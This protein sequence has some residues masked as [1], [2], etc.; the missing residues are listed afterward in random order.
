MTVSRIVYDPDVRFIL[1]GGKGGVGKTSCA[2]AISILSAEQGLRTLIVS[3]DPAH[4]LSD[5]FDQNLSGGEAV[6]IEQVRD[7]WGM[8]VDT[9][10]GMREFQKSIGSGVLGEETSMAIALIGDLDS[11]TPPGADEAMSFGKMLE[12]I[13]DNSYDR[14][15]FDTAPTGHT[16]K[17]LELPDLLDSWIGKIVTMRQRFSSLL[18]GIRGMFGGPQQEDDSWEALKATKE[19][20][21]AAR[22]ILSD[23]A[24]TQF[25]VVMIPETMALFETQRL[26]ASL[27]TWKIPVSHMI[28]NQVVP[29]N[30]SCRFCT[31][32][33]EMQRRNILDIRDIYRDLEITEVPLFDREIRGIN[34][35]RTLARI[36]VGEVEMK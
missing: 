2:A 5:S 7:L 6:A 22:D 34:E 36:L 29:E 23:P 1:S 8:E 35:L 14:I 17:L 26:M 13:S 16:L 18:S 12:F 19:K 20:I 3:T 9:K 33:H 11:M 24:M 31:V 32:R 28:I 15:V 4:S 25:I 21:R 10:K 30:P 27:N